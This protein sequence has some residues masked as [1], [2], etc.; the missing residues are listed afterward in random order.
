MHFASSGP[1]LEY[2]G[3][4]L[5]PDKPFRRTSHRHAA[6]VAMMERMHHEERIAGGRIIWVDWRLDRDPGRASHDWRASVGRTA[7]TRNTSYANQGTEQRNAN[8][9]AGTGHDDLHEDVCGLDA[10][11]RRGA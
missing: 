9:G 6:R 4:A 5:A 1:T 7:D 2:D 10:A 11:D 3:A 8:E